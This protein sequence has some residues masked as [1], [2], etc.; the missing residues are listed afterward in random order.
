MGGPAPDYGHRRK[1]LPAALYLCHRHQS[2]DA[3]EA[4]QLWQNGQSLSLS[5]T[6]SSSISFSVEGFGVIVISYIS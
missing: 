1:Y 3:G 2:P 6:L 4:L 5:L